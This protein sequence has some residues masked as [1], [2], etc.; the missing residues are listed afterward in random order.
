MGPAEAHGSLDSLRPGCALG[1]GEAA[2]RVPT[3]GRPASPVVV[4]MEEA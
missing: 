3:E 1:W 4:T 2:P